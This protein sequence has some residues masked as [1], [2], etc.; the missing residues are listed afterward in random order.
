MENGDLICEIM[1]LE[2]VN[3]Q[4]LKDVEAKMMFCERDRISKASSFIQL[5]VVFLKITM[6][7]Q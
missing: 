1:L 5:V 6:T 3:Y 4:Q 2:E 7:H